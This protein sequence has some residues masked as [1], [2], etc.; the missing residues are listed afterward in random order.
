MGL[1]AVQG[2]CLPRNAACI[3][4]LQPCGNAFKLL[5]FLCRLF[6]KLFV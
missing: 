4:R 5:V 3:K 6:N 1:K 2:P